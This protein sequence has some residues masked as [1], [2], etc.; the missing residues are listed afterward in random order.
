M[1][2]DACDTP[3]PGY[4]LQ[5]DLSDKSL[6]DYDDDSKYKVGSTSLSDTNESEESFGLNHRLV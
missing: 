3:E 6:D 5:D 2:G 4:S 1:K